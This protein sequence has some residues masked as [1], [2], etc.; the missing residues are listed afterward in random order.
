MR[1]CCNGARRTLNAGLLPGALAVAVVSYIGQIALGQL[2]ARK[3]G[4]P[5]VDS[6]RELLALGL[7][8]LLTSFVPSQPANASF[9]RTA[10]NE[11]AGAK[12]QLSNIVGV[13]IVVLVLEVLTS[14]KRFLFC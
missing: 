11:H 6:S 1:I 2:Y 5:D 9:S 14:G 3:N 12:T 4:Q 13:V 7:A 10:V 8:N